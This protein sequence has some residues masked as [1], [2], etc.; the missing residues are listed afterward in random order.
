M[1]HHEHAA[2][3]GHGD[4]MFCLMASCELE[5]VIVGG[6]FIHNVTAERA[7]THITHITAARKKRKTLLAL[8]PAFSITSRRSCFPKSCCKFVYI[9]VHTHTHKERERERE[10][11][12]ETERERG[13]QRDRER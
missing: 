1:I 5:P 6:G 4:V 9:Y 10:R 7:H 11:E 13:R 8:R 12:R 2:V 3:Q